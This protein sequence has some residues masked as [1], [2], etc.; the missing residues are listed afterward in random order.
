MT[1]KGILPLSVYNWLQ[2]SI[3]LTGT[4]YVRS[5]DRIDDEEWLALPHETPDCF[6]QVLEHP[7]LHG[8]HDRHEP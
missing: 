8:V 4:Y 3:E 6:H 2:V 5:E 1:W 7:I